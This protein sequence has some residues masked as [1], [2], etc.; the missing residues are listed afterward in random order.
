MMSEIKKVDYIYVVDSNGTPLMPT[1]RLGMVRRWLKTGQAKW[2]GN[3]RNTIQFV[4]PVTTNT[5][6]LTLG[7][8][9]GF[10]LGLSVVGNNREY[11]VSESLRKSEKDRI[12]SRRELRRTRR[13]RL[14]YRKA[15]FNNRR[16]KDGWLAPSIQHRLDFTIKEIK[17]LYKFLPITNLVVE[18]TPF[19]NQKLL[20]PD[21]QGWQYQKGKMY[22]FKTIKDYLLARDNYRD[23]LDGKQYPAS[24]LRVHHLVQRKDGGSNQPDNLVL[25]SDINHN[26]ANHNNGILAK[27]RENRQKTLDYR[28]AYFMSILATRLSNYFEHYTTTQGYL[29]ANLRQKLRNNN[30]VLQKFYDAKYIDSR[31]GKQ[32]AG[33]ELSSGRTRRSQELNY[34]NLRQLRKEKVKKGR[35]SI[36]RGHYQLRPHDVVLNTRTNRIETVKGVQNSGTVIKFQTGKTCSIKSVVSLYHVNGILEKKMKNI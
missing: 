12:T 32:K 28:G 15:R 16:R 20:N 35:V 30:R 33:K 26:Q 5:Q 17:R 36:R 10:H 25:L 11:Y 29:T 23:A 7:V 19:D 1:S 13:N 24:Q 21:I 31:D 14:R 22:G 8:D 9:A 6:E 4:R 3:S 18:V 34:D 2:F 27:L